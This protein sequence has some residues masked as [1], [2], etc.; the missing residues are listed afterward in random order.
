M[1][2]QNYEKLI[3]LFES[4]DYLKSF[5]FRNKRMLLWSKAQEMPAAI[6]PPVLGSTSHSINSGDWLDQKN[7]DDDE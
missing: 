3:G 4:I 2:E 5:L 6:D 7:N 1:E